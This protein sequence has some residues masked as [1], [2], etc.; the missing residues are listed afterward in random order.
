MRNYL[1][2]RLGRVKL[3]QLSPQHVRELHAWM[4]NEKKLSLTTVNHTHGVLGHALKDAQRMGLVARNVAELVDPPRKNKRR[5]VIYTPEQ[6]AK[7]LEA[8]KGEPIEPIIT[9]S[10]TT[11]A[12]L[13]E[14]LAVKRANVD[15][16][17]ATITIHTGRAQ[18]EDGWADTEPKTDAANRTISLTA[19]AVALLREHRKAQIE[20]RLWLGDA[21]QD[22]DYVFPNE[23]GGSQVHSVIDHRF[24]KLVTQVGLPPIRIHDLRHTVGSLLL[25]QG[26]PVPEVARILGHASPDI[27]YRLYAHAIPQAQRRALDAMERI[28]KG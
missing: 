12:R 16:D 23:V 5:S 27:T 8:L 26:V 24:K 9:L 14:L 11:G 4:L 19:H 25:A 6:L 3:A 13:G 7:L 18:V 2:P 10:A 1:I 22:N 15:L 28:L 21:W 20:R 17:H